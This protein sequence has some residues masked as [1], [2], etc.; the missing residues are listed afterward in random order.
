MEDGSGG[1]GIHTFAAGS[2]GIYFTPGLIQTRD[3]V[4]SRT[5]IPY[6]PYVGTFY[7][8]ADPHAAGTEDATVV[9]NA[10]H[11]M[12]QVYPPGRGSGR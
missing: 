2:T 8:V 3:D 5:A 11:R 9:V 6:I 12:G 10:K 7:F 1:A 4:T